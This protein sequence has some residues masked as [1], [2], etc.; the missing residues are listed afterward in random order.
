MKA[1]RSKLDARSRR[2]LERPGKRG[3]ID[4]L[5][6]LAEP[7]TN[8]QRKALICA[9]CRITAAA[10][11]VVSGSIDAARVDELAALDFVRSIE[12]GRPLRP[13]G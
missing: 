9:G 8:A 13:E 12:T 6:R 11:A 3:D 2:E 7:P 5:V 10:G 1:P 4:V